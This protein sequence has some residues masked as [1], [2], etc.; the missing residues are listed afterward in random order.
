[1]LVSVI[2]HEVLRYAVRHGLLDED[3]VSDVDAPALATLVTA[4][5]RNLRALGCHLSQKTE[6]FLDGQVACFDVTVAGT[7]L[8][9]SK[10]LR[11]RCRYAGGVNQPGFVKGF[12][13]W[14]VA[15]VQMRVSPERFEFAV[16]VSWGSLVACN[17]QH[18]LVKNAGKRARPGAID[19]YTVKTGLSCQLGLSSK[20][21]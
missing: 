8:K 20:N 13:K 17:G 10:L 1:V 2:R 19:N 4:S 5:M 9:C 6:F 16:H 21:R 3:A 11:P 18:I 12:E 15:P 7:R 14:R